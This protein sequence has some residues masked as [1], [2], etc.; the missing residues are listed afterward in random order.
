MKRLFLAG[1]LIC[2]VTANSAVS[3]VAAPVAAQAEQ[4]EWLTLLGR[5]SAMF[6]TEFRKPFDQGNYRGV[7]AIV[8]Q[9]ERSATRQFGSGSD[10]YLRV[11]R[12]RAYYLGFSG[13]FDKQLQISN[14]ILKLRTA[15]MDKG[16]LP[17]A[18]ALTQSV[19]SL[20]YYN[21][22]HKIIGAQTLQQARDVLT[23]LGP[24]DRDELADA[25]FFYAS[26]VVFFEGER[27]DRIGVVSKIADFRA[28]QN[29]VDVDDYV[30]T[31][32]MLGSDYA[33][34]ENP[35]ANRSALVSFRNALTAAENDVRPEKKHLGSAQFYYGD[36]LLKMGQAAEAETYL[37]RAVETLTKPGSGAYAQLASYARERLE[38]AKA[39]KAGNL[40]KAEATR[41]QAVETAATDATRKGEIVSTPALAKLLGSLRIGRGDMNKTGAV[42]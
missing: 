7:L 38:A 34:V 8:D 24:I 2:L 1:A 22:N 19:S 10:A 33:S 42:K 23:S 21:D 18:N 9:A 39:A 17:Y 13:D 35:V 37:K 4:A 20:T 29:P 30:A 15:K 27:K 6:N 25:W 11:L 26:Q 32:S 36:Q 5:A 31:Y 41:R 3:Q 16:S 40:A 28:S 12:A 14:K